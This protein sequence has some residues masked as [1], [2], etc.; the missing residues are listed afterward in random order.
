MAQD[1]P[2]SSYRRAVPLFAT[3]RWGGFFPGG[4]LRRRFPEED[5]LLGGRTFAGAGVLTFRHGAAIQRT[6]S[7]ARSKTTG[8]FGSH[9]LDG[10]P[11]RQTGQ[12]A[13]QWLTSRAAPGGRRNPAD[14]L[15]GPDQPS[16]S[17]DQASAGLAF[18]SIQYPDHL[19][20][21]ESHRD[22]S[23]Q[24]LP[25][26]TDPARTGRTDSRRPSSLLCPEQS[27]GRKVRRLGCTAGCSRPKRE[28]CSPC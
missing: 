28:I 4:L 5:P 15:H 25:G 17:A 22:P 9:K 16:S 7:T 3:G 21:R 8:S 23:P 14:E 19:H 24:N 6:P 12:P 2:L 20:A 11:A 18:R 10:H 27:H 26:Q 1:Q 13:S